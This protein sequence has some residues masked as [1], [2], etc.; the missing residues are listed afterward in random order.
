[1]ITI[2]QIDE[3]R[4]RT[5][6][7][8]EDARV[9][10]ER[11]QG[12]VLDA[13]IDFEKTK[14]AWR[15]PVK[16][17]QQKGDFGRWILELLQKGFDLRMTVEDKTGKLLFTV[18]ILL[19][20]LL[21]P[22]WPMLLIS[23]LFLILL[24]FKLGFRDIKS[25]AVNVK[26]IFNTVGSQ[27]RDASGHASQRDMRGAHGQP[28]PAGNIRGAHGQPGPAANMR[29]AHGQP[30]PA[31]NMRGAHGQ[32]GPAGNMRGAHGQPGP[33]GNMP[34]AYGQPGP[35]GNMPPQPGRGYNGMP[36]SAPMT[37]RP[38]GQEPPMTTQSFGRTSPQM[39]FHSPGQNPA[40]SPMAASMQQPMVPNAAP[41]ASAPVHPAATAHTQAPIGFIQPA[42][43][44]EDM[45]VGQVMTLPPQEPARQDANP[46]A[47]STH[48]TRNETIQMPP[49][50][51]AVFQANKVQPEAIH[52]EIPREETEQQETQTPAS[53]RTETVRRDVDQMETVRRE[54]LQST[55]TRMEAVEPNA[56]Q[57]GI[58]RV[59]PDRLMMPET[60]PVMDFPQDDDGFAE[61]TIE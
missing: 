14:A 33:A 7:S 54:V 37:G 17:P 9:F 47:R 18:P 40:R 23:C 44:G 45:P 26:E 59:K 3:F 57:P 31:G 30:G 32:P 52:L 61:F 53:A 15:P 11:H 29:G 19:L 48:E 42:K 10:L 16:K 50:Q 4:K 24:G 25:T 39:S 2:E 55:S 13:I 28:G 49:V 43:P 41:S 58:D 1:M 27:F 5:N 6:S 35:A 34:G 46:M 12:D 8:Y 51:Q 60:Q 20:L 38:V 21:T 56:S 22:A 36:G